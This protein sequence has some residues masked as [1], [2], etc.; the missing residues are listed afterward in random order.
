MRKRFTRGE[1]LK[2]SR[3]YHESLIE[4]LK[5]PLEACAYLNVALEEGDRAHFLV[6]LRNVAE[7]Q[8]GLLALA[9]RAKMNRG[10]LYHLLSKGGNPEIESLHQILHTFGLD[11]A[12]I[13][14]KPRKLNKAA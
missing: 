11:L 1:P 4:A 14:G 10:H 7:A 6:A 9:R 8:G 13:P 12:I 2:P 5:D 3:S